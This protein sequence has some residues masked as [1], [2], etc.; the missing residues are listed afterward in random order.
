MLHEP[1]QMRLSH[2][3]RAPDALFVSNANLNR[4]KENYLDDAAALVVE[5]VSPSSRARDRG[6]KFYEYEAAGRV[7]P[8][9]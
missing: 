5:V 8:A 2:S 1:F 7:L 3:S 4:L 6:E 9:G